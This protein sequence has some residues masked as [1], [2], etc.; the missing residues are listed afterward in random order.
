M[1]VSTCCGLRLRLLFFVCR[2][3]IGCVFCCLSSS[4]FLGFLVVFPCVDFVSLSCVSLL[5]LFVVLLVC[6][7]LFV[8]CLCFLLCVPCCVCVC[9]LGFVVLLFLFVARCFELVF[10]FVFSLLCFMLVCSVL[11]R[12]CFRV[13]VCGF[14][15]G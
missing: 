6:V 2:C 9:S 14:V 7:V 15:C 3:A 11:V 12:A 4:Y 1:C 13:F 8:R 5:C 10:M